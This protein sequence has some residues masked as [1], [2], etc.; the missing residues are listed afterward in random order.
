MQAMVLPLSVRGAL[1]MGKRSRIAAIALL[2]YD[3]LL[4]LGLEVDL[5]WKEKK[6]RSGFGL[7]IFV[8]IDA[9]VVEF[10]N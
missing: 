10:D 4:S 1:D 3:H 5:I 8:S 2:V 7:Y 6:T 9:F